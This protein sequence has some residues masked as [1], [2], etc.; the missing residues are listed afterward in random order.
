LEGV[1]SQVFKKRFD[2]GIDDMGYGSE[3]ERT[4]ETRGTLRMDRAEP[5]GTIHEIAR[6]FTDI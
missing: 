3:A 4:T 1:S 6:N 5:K 2:S